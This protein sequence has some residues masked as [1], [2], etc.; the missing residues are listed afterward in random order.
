MALSRVHVVRPVAEMS[1][2]CW[3]LNA[4]REGGAAQWKPVFAVLTERDFLLYEA[5]P[6]TKEQ[7][8]APFHTH[9]VVATR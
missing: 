2:S 5:A 9:A 1:S 3:Q 8:A 6:V 4:E 7:W